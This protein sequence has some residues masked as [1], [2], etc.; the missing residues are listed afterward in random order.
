MAAVIQ[1][2]IGVI[3]L[4]CAYAI[5]LFFGMA[6]AVAVPFLCFPMLGLGTLGTLLIFRSLSGFVMKFVQNRPGL[7]FKNLNV[8]TLRQWISKVHTT[9]LAQTVVC[10]LLLLA[11]GITAS[12]IGLNSTI[13]GNTDERAPFDIT[14]QNQSG[15]VEL[16]DFRNLIP[17][18]LVTWQYDAL[19]YYNDPEITGIIQNPKWVT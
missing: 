12:C 4:A 3:C 7:Y 19:F 14:V 9:Y 11:I 15:D 6:L 13:E 1:L 16:V 10:I 2:V 18:D 8:F 5:L 17:Q